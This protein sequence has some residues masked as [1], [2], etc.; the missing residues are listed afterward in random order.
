MEADRMLAI[1]D[2]LAARL[3]RLSTLL[4]DEAERLKV[5][6]IDGLDTLLAEKQAALQA[7]DAADAERRR[8]LH[9]CGYETGDAGMRRYL[10][11]HHGAELQQRWES[12]LGLLQRVQMLNEA[13]GRIIHRGLAQ[14]EQMLDLLR[15]GSGRSNDVYGPS[16][17]TGIK[18]AG[19]I[20]SRA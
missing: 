14:V 15:G 17:Q 4:E 13:N 8:L 16:G 12:L 20:L 9:D 5:R 3:Q 6:D 1:L 19:R 2:T 7:V 10:A 11:K 18:P